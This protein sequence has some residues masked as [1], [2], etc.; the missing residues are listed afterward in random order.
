MGCCWLLRTLEHAENDRACRYACSDVLSQLESTRAVVS[1][2]LPPP[3]AAVCL[4]CGRCEAATQDRPWSFN[5]FEI[6]TGTCTVYAPPCEHARADPRAHTP[7]DPYTP[8]R[9]QCGGCRGSRKSMPKRSRTTMARCR[10]TGGISPAVS[11]ASE[12]L[13]EPQL[14]VQRLLVPMIVAV[15]GAL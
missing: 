13:M 8:R 6:L 10:S 5:L 15:G 9:L 1:S 4:C 2:S 7:I 12:A 3:H 11:T 14:A